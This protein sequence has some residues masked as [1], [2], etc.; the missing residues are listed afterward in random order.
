MAK[1]MATSVWGF[2]RENRMNGK[3]RNG[4]VRTVSDKLIEVSLM[5]KDK[6]KIGI[7]L[8][9]GDGLGI[10]MTRN[11]ARMLARR[12]NECLEATK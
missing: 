4:Y 3:W 1:H 11:E 8:T 5:P 9:G 10:R 2:W 6:I 7:D 12:I